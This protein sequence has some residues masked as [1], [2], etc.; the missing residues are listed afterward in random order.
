MNGIN[1]CGPIK[2]QIKLHNHVDAYN[3]VLIG[4]TSFSETLGGI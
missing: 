1:V 2:M 3:F 4:P